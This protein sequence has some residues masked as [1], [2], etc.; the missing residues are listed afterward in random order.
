VSANVSS[1]RATAGLTYRGSW[2]GYDWVSYYSALAQGAEP[3]TSMRVYWVRYPSTTRPYVMVSRRPGQKLD[4]F[5]RV[6]NL[7]N[8]QRD[9]RDNL[10]VTAGRTISAGMGMKFE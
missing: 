7:T 10:Q 3:P 1:L 5:V 2:T 6:D 8:Q 4:W 9:T